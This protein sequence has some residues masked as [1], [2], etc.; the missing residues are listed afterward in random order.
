LRQSRV[1]VVLLTLLLSGG[2][3]SRPAAGE[4][5]IMPEG[6]FYYQPAASV[7]G[8]EAAWINPAALARYRIAGFQFMADYFEGKYGKNYGSVV[9]REG[10]ALAYRRIYNP[11]F[12]DYVEYTLA[13]AMR[14]GRDLSLGGSYQHFKQG[15]GIFDNRHFWNLGLGFHPE[16][17]FSFG[18][19]F[20]NLNRGKIGDERTETEQRYSLSWRPGRYDLTLSVDMFLSTKTR[21]SNADYVWHGEFS[22]QKGLYVNGFIDN[23][24]NFQVGIRANLRQYFGGAR[25]S[26]NKNGDHRG[27]TFFFGATSARQPSLMRDRVRRLSVGLKGRPQENPPQPVFGR[28]ETPYVTTLL[29]IYRA[30]DD[31]SIGEMVITLNRLTMGMGQAQELHEALRYFRSKDKFIT[32]HISYPNNISYFVASACNQVLIPPVSELNLVGLRA[33]LTFYAGTLEKLGVKADI[34]RIGEY[35]TAPERYTHRSASEENREQVNR[36]LDD[37]FNQFVTGI[38]QGRGISAD[39]VRML[40]DSGPFTSAEALEY[41]LVDG[42]SYKD[43]LKNNFLSKMPE[44]SIHKYLTDTVVNDTWY[45]RPKLAVV[46][47][48]GEVSF[49]GGDRGPFGNPTDVTPVKMD[50][51]F[52]RARRDKEI[53]GIIFRINSP[54]G[55]ALAGEEILRSA[56]RTAEKKPVVVSMANVAASGGYYIAMPASYILANPATVTGSIG[57]YGGKMDLSGLYQ[58]IDVGKELYTR[59]KYAGLL[60]TMRPFTPEE[61]EKYSSHME[62]FYGHFLSLVSGNRALPVDSIDNLARGRVFTGREAK[63]NGLVD[64]LGGIKAALDITAGQLGL[65][66]YSVELLPLKRPWFL[67]PG[68]SLLKSVGGL[69]GLGRGDAAVA[70]QLTEV[71]PVDGIMARL[72][73]DLAIE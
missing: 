23:D 10:L 2:L 26:S 63:D 35:K 45:H 64:E 70:G 72:P 71:I 5:I 56:F 29:N 3:C 55:L 37:L 54:G 32:C 61:R 4:R 42:L 30:A 9:G 15:E 27:S 12:E 66:D 21:L 68:E 73:Y 34:V 44:I 51:A 50:K 48:A 24:K 43:E 57:I 39:S 60:T 25:R 13:G 38:G 36:L 62:A 49:D 22:P 59:G 69:I 7:F 18:A 1:V 19:V 52:R 65:D 46:V 17:H 58:K 16:G 47:A 33:E 11:D 53:K 31:P 28:K 40:V 6:V 67:L 14:L 20:S 41:G 8:T